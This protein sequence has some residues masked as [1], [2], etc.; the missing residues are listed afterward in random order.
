MAHMKTPAQR[1]S[2]GDPAADGKVDR[3]AQPGEPRAAT[4]VRL[5]ERADVPISQDADFLVFH[6]NRAPITK[7]EVTALL[8]QDD[9]E[10]ISRSIRG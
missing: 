1:R 8:D 5:V 10:L 9:A 7:E 3:N 2:G 4:V 6:P